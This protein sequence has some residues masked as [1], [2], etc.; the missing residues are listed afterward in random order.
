MK[1]Y[2]ISYGVVDEEPAFGEWV[3]WEDVEALQAERD[4]LHDE[5]R[6]LDVELG[7][8]K[9]ERDD[10]Q[11]KLDALRRALAAAKGDLT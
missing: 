5:N 7:A 6:S 3:K 4:A 1:R 11:A 9:A 10:L 8:V 2:E